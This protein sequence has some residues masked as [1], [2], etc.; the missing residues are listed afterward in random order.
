MENIEKQL[1]III[2][3]I[4]SQNTTLN[5]SDSL[6]LV[7]DL[8]FNSLDMVLLIIRIEEHFNIELSSNDLQKN[9][10]SSYKNIKYLLESKL[11]IK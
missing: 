10:F 9:K 11:N 2:C 7:D 1:Q 6:D 3:D 5:F 4:K 8:N